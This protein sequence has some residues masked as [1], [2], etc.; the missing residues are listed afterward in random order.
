[1]TLTGYFGGGNRLPQSPLNNCFDRH[2][3]RIVSECEE[4]EQER[5]T[6]FRVG[7]LPICFALATSKDQQNRSIRRWL[8]LLLFRAR[9]AVSD[10]RHGSIGIGS[11][12]LFVEMEIAGMTG[13]FLF[14]ASSH[15]VGFS[16]CFS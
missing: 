12:Q 3:R 1:M 16:E 14:W 8:V 13:R 15:W 5:S 4:K 9:I 10:W 2:L 7:Q 11:E 6:S